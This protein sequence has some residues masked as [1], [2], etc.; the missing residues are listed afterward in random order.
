MERP[1]A[2]TA[3]ERV[4]VRNV[5]GPRDRHAELARDVRAGLTGP[6][7]EIPPKYFY[8]ARGSHLFERITDL[9]E[10]YLTRAETE[11]LELHAVDFVSDI[12]AH[13]LVEYG[14][15]SSTKTR[16]LLDAMRAQGTLEGYAPVD[17]SEDALHA[18]ADLL[19]D[20]YP[21]LQ[22]VIVV[23][24]FDAPLDLSFAGRPQ[25]IAFLG[26][27]IGN[28]TTEAAGRFM[29]CV[30][31]ELEPGDG[32]LIGFDLVKDARVLE[33]AYD[34][35]AG[36]TAAFNLNVL[37]A[38][39]RELH[40]DFDEKTFRHR[41]FYDSERARIEMHLVSETAQSVCIAD[42]DLEVRFQAG[43][44]IRTE[45]SHK[46]TPESAR[47]LLEAGGLRV[48]RWETDGANR[49]ALALAERR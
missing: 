35:A 31:E 18:A 32:F 23:A 3:D 17:V 38:L 1:S 42:L 20:E 47:S 49:F 46:Y 26:S 14:S 6:V 28:F 45:L 34:D 11:I 41:A 43:E 29:E 16:L 25:L 21:E 2:G 24:D 22:V 12:G 48:S 15:G 30:A 5:L 39:N 19:V 10:Y 4:V 36:V 8:D 9:P 33:A 40:A 37:R 7:K 13:V 27:T 44:S